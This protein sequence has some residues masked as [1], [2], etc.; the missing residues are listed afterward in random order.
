MR[1][2]AVPTREELLTSRGL[3]A[4]TAHLA[5]GLAA[6]LEERCTKQSEAAGAAAFLRAWSESVRGGSEPVSGGQ[7]ID[8]VAA[9]YGLSGA[10]CDLL[11]LAGLP[12][13]HEGLA[14]TFRQMH[15]RGEP[16]PTAGVGA[17]RLASQRCALVPH[18]CCAFEL[19]AP[20]SVAA[21]GHQRAGSK[22]VLA[23]RL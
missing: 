5:A 18:A 2:V 11:L 23:R 7:P 13:E 4:R 15:P 3:S 1:D 8:R 17:H 19:L 6:L 9:S 10:E 16:H 22:R 21:G 20:H 14:S 12:E